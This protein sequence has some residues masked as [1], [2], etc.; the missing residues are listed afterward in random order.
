MPQAN[1]YKVAEKLY[2]VEQDLASGS[3][4]TV[5]AAEVPTDHIMIYDCSGSM[6]WDLPKIRE[7]VKKKLPK[8]LKE[9]DTFSAIW[10]SGRGECGVLLEKEP[11]ATLKDLQEVEKAVDRWLKPVG[12]TG[13]K[14][15]LEKAVELAGRLGGKGR[16]VAVT[17]MSDGCDNQS[18]RADI[19]KVAEKLGPKVSSTTIVEYGYYADRPLLTAMAEKAGGSLIFAEDFDRYQPAFEAAMSKKAS[20]A[21]RVEIKVEGDPIGGI[22]YALRDGDLITYCLTGNAASVPEDLQRVFYLSPS[23]IGKDEGTLQDRSKSAANKEVPTSVVLE[24]AYGAVSLFAI[25]MNS[26]IVFPLLKSLGDVRLIEQFSSCFGKQKYSEFMEETKNAAFGKA[27]RWEKGWDPNKVPRDDAFTV[28]DLLNLLAQDDS[29]RILMEHP[30]FKYSKIGRGR[31]DATANLTDAEVAEV[32]TL[33]AQLTGEKDPKKIKGINDKIAAITD[34]KA[35]TL[36]FV[37]D[38]APDGYSISNLTFNEDRPNV[39]VLV[40]KSGTVDIA[41]RLK[42]CPAGTTAIPAK[43]PTH[44]W[45]NY[46][47]IKDGLVNVDILPLLVSATTFKKLL[48]EKIIGTD[49]A[50]KFGTKGDLTHVFVSLKALPVINRKMVNNISA[51]AFFETQWE[52]TKAQA[53]QKVYKA[54]VKDLLP[55]KKAEGIVATYGDKAAEWLKAQ[56]LSDGGFQPP[57]TT[58]AEATGDVYKSKELK[59]SLKGYAKLPSIK[60]VKEMTSKG[61]VNPPGALMKPIVDSVEAFLASDLYKS[62]ANKEKILESWLDGEAKAAT[63]KARKLIYDTARTTITVIVGQKWFSEFNSLD[64]NTLTID[65]DGQKV[66]GKVEMVEKDIKL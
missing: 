38:S 51:K 25:R 30:Q 19:L 37:A 20:S 41:A 1:S 17:F 46:A 11:V 59:T 9:A 16:A 55:P 40:K 42:D 26:D 15:P 22:V 10:F 12:L 3:K 23:C 2:L 64:E 56:G 63:A 53:A 35:D 13:F 14:D 31:V 39:S 36:K 4:E 57:K 29:N 5:T 61:K 60:E 8:M 62:A 7:Q 48:D 54:Y 34:G 49:P 28:L 27:A 65:V 58:Q 66:E 6:S 33:S 45:R 50:D 47:I 44:V 32:A 52:L 43:F 21:P 18:N 24:A